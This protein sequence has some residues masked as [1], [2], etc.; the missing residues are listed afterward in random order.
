MQKPSLHPLRL[1]RVDEYSLENDAPPIK[2]GREN[3]DTGHAGNLAS[4]MKVHPDIPIENRETLVNMPAPI[5]ESQRAQRDTEAQRLLKRTP[6]NYLF[7]QIY[8]L[9]L[10]L[11]LFLI[12]LILTHKASTTENGTY[13]IIQTAI[14]TITYIAALGLEDAIVTFVPR[15]RLERGED[16]ARYLIRQILFFRIAVLIACTCIILF[17]LPMLAWLIN[18]IPIQG[19]KGISENLQNPDLLRHT[20]PIALYVLG[21]S[22]TNLLQAVCAAQMRML[23]VL[24]VGGLVQL[25]LVIFGFAVLNLGWGIDSVFW[26]QATVALLGASAFLLWLSPLLLAHKVDNKQPLRPILQFGFSAWLTNLASGALF[27]QVSITLLTIYAFSYAATHDIYLQKVSYFNYSFQMADAANALLVAGFA[28]VGASALATS[29]VGNNYERLGLSWQSL[30]KVETLLA[31]PGLIFALFNAS[32]LAIAIYGPEYAA[33]GR[34]LTI[35]LVF[36]IFFRII[37]TP[38]HQASLYVIGKTHI[39]VISQWV[40][41]LL[42][43]GIGILLVPRFGPAGALIADGIGKALTGVFMLGFLLRKL[44]RKY[45]LGLLSFTLRFL[46]GITIAALPGLLWRPSGLLQIVL[47][48]AVFIMLCLG[49]LLIIKPLSSEDLELITATKPKLARYIRWFTQ[50]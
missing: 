2:K 3:E 43:I 36:N 26:M 24:I 47:S 48:G 23:R 41:L 32:S 28:G 46:C 34:L 42:I 5:S 13:A 38:I 1:T 30:I 25:G 49:V 22:I 4:S 44:P 14:N 17:G 35:F 29:F 40:A 27:K 11:S 10:Y 20:K 6:N 15:I 31:V 18:L 16:A 21:A 33:I 19:T 12:S 7:N 45:P 8:G 9:W 37:G 50:K 39:V